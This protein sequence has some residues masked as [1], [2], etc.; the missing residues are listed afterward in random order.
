M[1][2]FQAKPPAAAAAT[3]LALIVVQALPRNTQ[4]QA[5]D[6]SHRGQRKAAPN[7]EASDVAPR[8]FRA[9]P[10]TLATPEAQRRT[11]PLERIPTETAV[12]RVSVSKG[13]GKR[14]SG[15]RAMIML[16]DEFFLKLS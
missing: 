7:K 14:R 4:T 9:G 3:S 2:I 11:A 13:G 5:P 6:H 8:G 12:K 15:N 10:A 16:F 1:F